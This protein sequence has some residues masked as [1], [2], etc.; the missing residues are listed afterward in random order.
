MDDISNKAVLGTL[1]KQ[2]KIIR[3]QKGLRQKI[4]A[5]RCGFHNSG[6]SAIESG[7]RNI[8]ILTLYKIAIALE[9]PIS[10]FFSDDDFNNLMEE[11]KKEII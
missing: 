3:I 8:S 7:L 1:G 11:Y 2:I 9:E 10:S 5:K 6:Y 4:I